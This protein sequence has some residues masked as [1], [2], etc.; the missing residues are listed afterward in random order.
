MYGPSYI[1]ILHYSD[2]PFSAFLR[3]ISHSWTGFLYIYTSNDKQ[4]QSG[5][6]LTEKYF[7]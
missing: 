5:G 7:P 2:N 4:R 6:L 1:F 3:T